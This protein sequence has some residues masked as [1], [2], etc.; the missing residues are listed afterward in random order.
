MRGSL[1][2][3]VSRKDLPWAEKL[4]IAPETEWNWRI[5]PFPADSG[6]SQ[7]EGD[8]LLALNSGEL[9]VHMLIRMEEVNGFSG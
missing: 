1:G 7:G 9:F 3:H 5:P 2:I 8:T 4:A 6:R